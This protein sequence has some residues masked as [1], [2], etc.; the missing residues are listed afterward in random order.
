VHKMFL[1]MAAMSLAAAFP[2]FLRGQRQI[3]T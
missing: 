2:S 1:L 3:A